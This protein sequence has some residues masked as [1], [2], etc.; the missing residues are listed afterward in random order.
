VGPFDP[1]TGFRIDGD[2]GA[3]PVVAVE[4]ETEIDVV[5]GIEP[6]PE[7]EAE[8]RARQAVGFRAGIGQVAGAHIKVIDIT[9]KPGDGAELRQPLGAVLEVGR[10]ANLIDAVLPDGGEASA[11]NGIEQAHTVDVVIAQL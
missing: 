3:A 6:W 2:G 10:D 1:L 9:S 5:L 11:F 4:T 8:L 7:D